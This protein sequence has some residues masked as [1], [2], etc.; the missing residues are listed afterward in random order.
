MSTE[1]QI[2][3]SGTPL[4]FCLPHPKE[5]QLFGPC[6][7]KA[8]QDCKKSA[9]KQRNFFNVINAGLALGLGRWFNFPF[10]VCGELEPGTGSGPEP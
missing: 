6:R 8:S 5:L 3:H 7:L 2:P 9:A 10:S 1:K 4:D